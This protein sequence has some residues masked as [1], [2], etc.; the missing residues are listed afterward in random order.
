MEV[1][2]CP[3]VELRDREL[4]GFAD[5]NLDEE[6][7]SYI[8]TLGVAEVGVPRLGL[9][10]VGRLGSGLVGLEGMRGGLRVL[11]SGILNQAVPP[12]EGVQSDCHAGSA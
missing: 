9:K 12:M 8:L 11:Q 3:Q 2:A 7:V 6:R 1:T 4:M 5:P 10:E